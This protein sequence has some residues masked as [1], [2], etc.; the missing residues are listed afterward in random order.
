MKKLYPNYS[1]VF[2]PLLVAAV[3][4]FATWRSEGLDCQ[5]NWYEMPQFLIS[6]IK[7]EQMLTD[8][9]KEDKNDG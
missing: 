3:V 8:N 4:I 2:N 9:D 1:K 7:L 6:W 5:P